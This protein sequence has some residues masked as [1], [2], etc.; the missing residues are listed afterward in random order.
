MKICNNI[1]GL[2]DCYG[3]CYDNGLCTSKCEC[4]DSLIV[5]EQLVKTLMLESRRHE[6]IT[7]N[8]KEKRKALWE[9]MNGAADDM[10]YINF[11][12]TKEGYAVG[13]SLE[14]VIEDYHGDN[15]KKKASFWQNKYE[16]LGADYTHT[17]CCYTNCENT[18][19][20]AIGLDENKELRFHV[21][22]FICD[23]YKNISTSGTI[24][25]AVESYKHTIHKCLNRE[26][27]R[28]DE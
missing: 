10:K 18:I 25:E 13:T 24:E 12:F 3:G 22:L 16:R 21:E 28:I 17:I 20:L 9:F 26:Y 14:K 15:A 6:T 8:A 4:K 1:D 2:L 7:N 19:H 27:G 11:K 5:D 23:N